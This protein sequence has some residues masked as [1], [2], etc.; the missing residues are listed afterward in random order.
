MLP[1]IQQIIYQ[2]EAEHGRAERLSQHVELEYGLGF[3]RTRLPQDVP[4][5]RG[6]FEGGIA[7]LAADGCNGMRG[8]T[9]QDR[10]GAMDL[11]APH[12]AMHGNPKP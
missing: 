10:P 8:V 6:I 12:P 9:Q 4:E 2:L 3:R 7:A 1:I 11:R 5:D